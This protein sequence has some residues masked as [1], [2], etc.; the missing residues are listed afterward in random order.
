MAVEVQYPS[1]DPIIFVSNIGLR[2]RF[3]CALQSSQYSNNRGH[4]LEQ[5]N[6]CKGKGILFQ[7]GSESQPFFG[8]YLLLS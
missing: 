2:I 5:E 8:Q 1:W 6:N 4:N 7:S 3:A